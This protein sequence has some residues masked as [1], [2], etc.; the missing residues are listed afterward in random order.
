VLP[1]AGSGDCL[2]IVQIEDG[3]LMELASAFLD[4]ANGY[5]VPVGS[6]VVLSSTSMLLRAGPAAYAEQVVRSF[7]RIRDAYKGSVRVVHGFPLLV[8]GVENEVLIRSLMDIDLWLTDVDKKRT[9]SLPDTISHYNKNLYRKTCDTPNTYGTHRIPYSLPHSLHSLDKGSFTS[10]GWEDVA[11]RLP[12]LQKEEEGLILGKMLEELNSKFALQLDLKPSTDRSGQEASDP[13]D[14]NDMLNVVFA[15]GSHS[16]RIL[17]TIQ[18]ES[19]RILDSTVPGFRLTERATAE[20]AADIAEVCAELPDNNTIVVCQ[21]FDNSIYYGAREEGD[22]LLPKKGLDR[23]YHVEGDLLIANK[24][25]FR[26]LFSLAT[27]IIR[28]ADGKLVILMIPLPRYL[29]EKCCS[30][31]SHITNKDSAG[32]EQIMREALT[33]IGTWMKAMA[34]MKRLKNVV[35]FN[36]MEPLGLIDDDFDE[37]RI[38]Q[39]WGADPVHPTEDAYSLIAEHLLAFAYQQI[40]EKRTAEAAAEAATAAG[41]STVHAAPKAAKPVRRESW[42]SGTEPVAKRQA[43]SHQVQNRFRPYPQRGGNSGRGSGRGAYSSGPVPWKR[44]FRGRGGRR[45]GRGGRR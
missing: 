27:Q 9:H 10:P 6:V 41:P 36:P 32:Y 21:L 33:A 22:R 30:D 45:G 3:T 23:R 25:A 42:I 39:L 29:F 40:G 2:A 12:T 37:D 13:H 18:D 43:H 20:M 31:P 1:S 5:D 14:P 16:S 15:G 26:E 19:V 8:E 28:S 17:D 24:T 34:E 35:L 44:G 7:A 11:T 4:L 38:L